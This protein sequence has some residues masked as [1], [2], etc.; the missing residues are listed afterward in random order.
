MH[1]DSMTRATD[2]AQFRLFPTAIGLCGLAWR[3]DVV[4]ASNLPEPSAAA[5]EARLIRRTGGAVAG[6]PPATVQRAID[7]ITGLLAGERCDLTFIRCDYGTSDAFRV[8]V[9]EITRS[10]PPGETT[11]YGLIAERLGNKRFAQ[12]VGQTMGHNPLPII[13]PCHRVMGANG[14]LTG[15]S[16]NGGVATKLRLLDIEQAAM[17]RGQGLFDRLPMAVKP[18]G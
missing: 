1:L 15:F 9:Y 7:A 8:Q 10:I 2:A 4:A 18:T 5:V 12:A 11:T 17:G 3:G 16:A 14:K 6:Q 13:V